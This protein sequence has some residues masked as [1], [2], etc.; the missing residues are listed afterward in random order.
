MQL[1]HSAVEMKEQ[2]MLMQG[3]WKRE[4]ELVIQLEKDLKFKEDLLSRVQDANAS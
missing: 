3:D 1:E 2:V 4:Q